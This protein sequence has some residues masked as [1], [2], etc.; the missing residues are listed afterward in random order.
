LRRPILLQRRGGAVGTPI[1][2]NLV[3]G[4]LGSLFGKRLTVTSPFTT[5]LASKRNGD[6]RAKMRGV[7][8]SRTAGARRTWELVFCPDDVFLAYAYGLNLRALT[9][10]SKLFSG[11]AAESCFDPTRLAWVSVTPS[12]PCIPEDGAEMTG[13]SRAHEKVP[14]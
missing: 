10:I 9:P 13:C 5:R 12:L 4:F 14:D 11:G 8:A 6:T 1:I 2:F 7:A 3:A